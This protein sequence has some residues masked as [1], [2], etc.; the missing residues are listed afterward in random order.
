MKNKYWIISLFLLSIS[1]LMID[2]CKKDLSGNKPS[3]STNDINMKTITT[4]SVQCGGVVSDNGG[5]QL[6][7]RGLC[8]SKKHMPIVQYKIDTISKLEYVYNSDSV[9]FL[10]TETGPFNVLIEGLQP[11]TTYYVRAFAKNANGI[12]YGAE[13]TFTTIAGTVGG[14]TIVYGTVKDADSNS[15]KTV[16][17]L[18]QVWMAEN[19]RVTKYK[20]GTKIPK[21]N[22]MITWAGLTSG[23]Y[24]AYDTTKNA[25]TIKT[26]GYLY[27]AYSV[28]TNKLCPEGWH[29]PVEADWTQLAKNLGDYPIA[30]AKLENNQSLY[31]IDNTIATNKSGF[32]AEPAGTRSSIGVFENAG[33]STTYWSFNSYNTASSYSKTLTN[34]T[35]ALNQTFGNKTSGLSVRC[36][37][38]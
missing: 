29:V 32:S 18:T 38:D 16:K 14:V 4:S 24:C 31:W 28:L 13:K 1:I 23:A 30:G 26:F 33:T 9:K 21:V 37:K 22:S 36:L 35:S 2:G 34:N 20:D 19:L 10:A 15:Y 3:V 6:L 5:S 12:S 8:W 7:G 27:N 25:D 17:I 11:Y